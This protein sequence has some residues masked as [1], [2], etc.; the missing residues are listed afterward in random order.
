MKAGTR[1]AK[2]TVGDFVRFMNEVAPEKLAQ[3][4]DNIG[5]LAG[6]AGSS[7][8]RA[9]FCID[10][11][12]PVAKEAARRKCDLV[13]AYH[14]PIFKPVS[15]LVA[16]ANSPAASVFG[17]I[18]DGIAIYSTHTAL[19]AAAG[20]TNDVLAEL[21]GLTSVDSLE[22]ADSA[23]PA[24]C[25]LVVFVPVS[26]IDGVANAMFAAGAGRIG[27]YEQCSFRAE[28]TGTFKGG[29]S[30]SPAVGTRGRFETVAETR[31]EV[32]LQKRQLAA[33]VRALIAAH[34]Y[35][36]P[37]FDIYPLLTPPARGI[38]RIGAL[39]PGTELKKLA[40]Q[41][42]R[43]SRAVTV[44]LVGDP[45]TTLK[46]AIIVA[47]AGGSLPFKA[48]L[49][50]GDVVIT[51]EIRHHD[52]LAVDR[53]GACAIALNHW[54]SERP[55]LGRLAE[56]LEASLKGVRALVSEEDREVFQPV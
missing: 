30:T 34:P 46:R 17:C 19:D 24:Q 27:E 28:G 43:K 48:V 50:P 44:Q 18:R 35:E 55:T 12:E 9:L 3:P 53:H 52:A 40:R 39:P 4:W 1:N 36:E 11:T 8:R 6:D 31:L 33:V 42:K 2:Y 5:L 26:S 41:L 15:R 45:E 13:M 32:V 37:A 54:S 56:Q 49:G 51:G 22:I 16:G 20:G 29:D 47:G 38:G 7:L 25:K 10:L 21:C 23:E 14:P